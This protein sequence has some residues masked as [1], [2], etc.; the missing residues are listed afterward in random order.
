VGTLDT[1][2]QNALTKREEKNESK[3]GSTQRKNEKEV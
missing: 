3:Q 2:L 1:S